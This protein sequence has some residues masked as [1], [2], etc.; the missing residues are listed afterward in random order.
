MGGQGYGLN[1]L[2]SAAICATG[3]AFSAGTASAQNILDPTPVAEQ[4]GRSVDNVNYEFSILGGSFQRNVLGS[5]SNVMFVASLATP[6]PF[7]E[8]FG[9]QIDAAIG[10]YDSGFTSAAAGLHLFWRDPSQGMIGIYGDWGY[11]NPEHAGRVG[12]EFAVYNDRWT[13]DVL[14]G[15]QFGQHVFSEF[16]DEVD[17]SYYVTD[18]TRA[19]IGHRL[20]SRGS[21]G[22]FSFEH[23]MVDEGLDGWSIFGEIE[24]GEDGYVSGW[25]GVKFAVGST[26]ATL[27]DRDRNSNLTVRIPRNLASVT[28]CGDLDVVRPA[29][30]LR[31][32][33]SNLCS[34]EDEINRL[35]STGIAKK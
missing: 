7:F 6:F 1:R 20:T 15:L 2:L 9:A 34:S 24:A 32:E 33:M 8:N 35:S 22:N 4:S 5:A 29:T 3:L 30:S 10:S 17:L 21:V 12:V 14:A 27:I 18:N 11:V 16:I 25:G 19:S 13:L 28:Q 31:A 23:L 26:A